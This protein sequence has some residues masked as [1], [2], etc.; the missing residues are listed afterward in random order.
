MV[1]F[2]FEAL[3]SIF[4]NFELKMTQIPTSLPNVKFSPAAR[5]CW[6][7]QHPTVRHKLKGTELM[8]V[9]LLIHDLVK[10]FLCL[11]MASGKCA[12]ILAIIFFYIFKA[13]NFHQAH[14]NASQIST[15]LIFNSLLYS[16][17]VMANKYGERDVDF[18]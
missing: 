7:I 3:N 4:L 6:S 11:I 16:R 10:R 13:N 15:A 14:N 12:K 8:N 18:Q 5:S 1:Q 17:Y 2:R 9:D